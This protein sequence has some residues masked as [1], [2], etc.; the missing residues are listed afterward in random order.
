MADTLPSNGRTALDQLRR[1]IAALTVLICI[2]FVHA[3]VMQIQ[4]SDRNRTLDAIS[5]DSSHIADYVDELESQP[6]IDLQSVFRAVFDMR[7][8]LCDAYPTHEV[9]RQG[10]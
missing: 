5:K 3:V 2:L 9:C 10:T 6:P 4:L 1:L 8:V 7:E